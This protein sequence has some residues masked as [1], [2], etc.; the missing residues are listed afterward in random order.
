MD[1]KSKNDYPSCELSNFCFH[2]FTFR[3]FKIN[4]M[5]GLLQSL[6]V[7]DIE[8]QK[9]FFSL[10]GFN[11]K[12]AGKN[13]DWKTSQTLYWQGIAMYRDG[14]EYSDFL[15][16]VYNA[17]SENEEFR[18]ALLDSGDEVLTHSI[19]KRD[20]RETILTEQE[21]CDRLMILRARIRDE[22]K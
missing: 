14:A 11:A 18:K 8:K 13:Y 1:I 5:E 3:G 15:N 20:Y 7:S 12:K 9:K 16:E 2:P 10:V 17:L 22:G 21:F 4:S 19:G 6:K